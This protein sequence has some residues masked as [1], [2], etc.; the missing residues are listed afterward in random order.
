MGPVWAQLPRLAI[1]ERLLAIG[2]TATFTLTGDAHTDPR[3]SRGQGV[4]SSNF[5][6]SSPPG[7]DGQHTLEEVQL[8]AGIGHPRQR[9]VSNSTAAQGRIVAITSQR[10]T[11]ALADGNHRILGVNFLSELAV[12]P[13]PNSRWSAPHVAATSRYNVPKID[14]SLCGLETAL[15]RSKPAGM[16]CLPSCDGCLPTCLARDA[17]R[18]ALTSGSSPG[19][20]RRH[21]S[22]LRTGPT[23]W[24]VPRR[25][26]VR[27]RQPIGHQSR[28]SSEVG[29]R[30]FHSRGREPAPGTPSRRVVA[31][32]ALIGK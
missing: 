32:G 5:A 23:C 13:L 9:R 1:T 2:A 20:A 18:T 30:L 7:L 3:R 4:E 11:V 29:R 16:R 15:A 6:G 28:S 26:C 10:P 14:P 27:V 24:R 8:G 22:R 25:R 31:E 12:V 17:G 19:V 21:G